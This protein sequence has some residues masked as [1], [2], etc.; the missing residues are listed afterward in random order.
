MSGFQYVFLLLNFLPISSGGWRL[1]AN[2]FSN[3]F[4]L[5]PLNFDWLRVDKQPNRKGKSLLTLLGLSRAL[6]RESDLLCNEGCPADHLCLPKPRP[7]HSPAQI[8][9]L[10]IEM[11][12]LLPPR[13]TF[14]QFW[15]LIVR[16][17]GCGF[18]FYVKRTLVKFFLTSSVLDNINLKRNCLGIYG[19]S[20]SVKYLLTPC[21]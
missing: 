4:L 3:Y 9:Q 17:F 10:R 16:S 7:P 14:H 6:V 2:P 18:R 8:L 11:S 21:L 5:K 20:A 1:E 19:D 13:S 12:F 15:K